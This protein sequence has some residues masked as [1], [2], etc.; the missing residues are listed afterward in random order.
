M[1]NRLQPGE[2]LRI[3]W[4]VMAAFRTNA[5]PLVQNIAQRSEYPVM[6]TAT[7]GIS[8][9]AGTY[10]H[11][12]SLTAVALLHLYQ[13]VLLELH[14]FF[15]RQRTALMQGKQSLQFGNVVPAGFGWCVG[16]V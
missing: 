1:E 16:T 9:R 7:T 12:C 14:K 11:G 3:S 8:N 5:R 10:W 4:L 6:T 2:G 15:L 13:K